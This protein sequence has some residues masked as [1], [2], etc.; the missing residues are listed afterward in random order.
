MKSRLVRLAEWVF[1]RPWP[2]KFGYHYTVMRQDAKKEVFVECLRL[3]CSWRSRG[4]VQDAVVRPHEGK[5]GQST[6]CV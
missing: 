6:S 3:G 1:V 5:H 4:I 2:C